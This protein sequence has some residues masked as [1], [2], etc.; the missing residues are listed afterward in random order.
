MADIGDWLLGS[1]DAFGAD[2]LD[3]YYLQ[4]AEKYRMR[5]QYSKTCRH[6]GE[7]GLRWMHTDRGWRLA[8]IAFEHTCTKPPLNATEGFEI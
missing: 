8:T 2:D 5:N 7:R 1:E 3:N 4:R 6:C